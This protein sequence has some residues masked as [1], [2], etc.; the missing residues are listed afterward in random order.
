MEDLIVNMSDHELF[1]VVKEI[2]IDS[3]RND[4][5]IESKRH[6]E[7]ARK[8]SIEAKSDVSMWLAFIQMKVY[9]E[10]TKRVLESYSFREFISKQ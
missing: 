1:M 10:F 9:E 7:L 5:I 8:C 6:R 3:K 2:R 4:G